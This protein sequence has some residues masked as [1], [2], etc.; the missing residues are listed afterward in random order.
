MKGIHTTDSPWDRTTLTAVIRHN[1]LQRI[2]KTNETLKKGGLVLLG[3]A[4]D[5]QTLALFM[6]KEFI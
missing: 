6:K 3:T 1:I 5:L 2:D 4:K